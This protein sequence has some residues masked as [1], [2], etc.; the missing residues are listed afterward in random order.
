MKNLVT[1]FLF[2]VSLNFA[3]AQNLD[4]HLDKEYAIAKNGIIDLRSS[5]AKVFINGTERTATAH[6]KIDREVTTKGWYSSKGEFK[7]SVEAENGNI[8][9][10]ENQ[11]Q[12]QVGIIGY[13]K[14]EYK[15]EIEVPTGV[16]LQIKGDDGDYW[17]KNIAG[18]ISLD[19][20]DADVELKNCNGNKFTFDL[21][22]GDLKMSGG[23]GSIE[24]DADDS[25]LTFEN[26]N[27]TSINANVDDGKL[28]IQ[29]SI[30]E[31][32][33]LFPKPAAV[34]I[35]CNPC[36]G[37]GSIG[38]IL[39]SSVSNTPIGVL[40]IGT[41]RPLWRCGCLRGTWNESAVLRRRNIGVNRTPSKQPTRT[42]NKTGGV[43]LRRSD[44][45]RFRSRA[46][47]G[48]T[49]SQDGCRDRNPG[50]FG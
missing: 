16:S 23:K 14:E 43:R 41:I 28:I 29:N 15:I 27:F 35:P 42:T 38:P 39:R 34:S 1:S 10:R 48:A 36:V 4:F 33:T 18:N 24:I 49:A 13:Y 25:D 5:D 22:D 26:A 32:G 30:T 3:F 47:A 9:I 50:L 40:T 8:S 19:L 12:V 6:I 11:N 37:T 2:L 44:Q 45:G 31:N 7:V 20:D 46:D 21:D 17:I